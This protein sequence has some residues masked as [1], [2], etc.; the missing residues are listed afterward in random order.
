M[1]EHNCKIKEMQF[2][3]LCVDNFLVLNLINDCV[4]NIMEKYSL[5]I[6]CVSK[7]CDVVVAETSK[8]DF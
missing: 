1:I 6:V 5:K 7:I 3:F 4:I 2:Y 8:I